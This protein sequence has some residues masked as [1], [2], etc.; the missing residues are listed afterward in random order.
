M[1]EIYGPVPVEDTLPSCAI[2]LVHGG[3]TKVRRF[4]LTIPAT[5]A[6]G[7]KTSRGAG[8]VHLCERCW[9]AATA[10][11]RHVTGRSRPRRRIAA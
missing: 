3:T 11:A 2:C 8:P 10:D 7:R 1:S 9:R 5:T 4:D 6:D